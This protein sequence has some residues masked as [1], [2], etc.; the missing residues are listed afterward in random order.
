MTPSTI[1]VFGT[2]FSCGG[3]FEWNSQ[4]KKKN[5]L[6]ETNYGSLKDKDQYK[7]SYPYHL[8]QFINKN[9]NKKVNLYN[10]AKSGYGNERIYH[11]IYKLL[12]NNELD[13]SSLCLI[14]FSDYG[15]KQFYDKRENSHFIVNYSYDENKNGINIQ[16]SNIAYEHFYDDKN[17]VDKLLDIKQNI[18]E[19]YDKTFDVDYIFKEIEQNIFMLLSTLEYHKIPYV[20]TTE[21]PLHPNL[22]N[23][24]KYYKNSIVEY[25]RGEYST[26]IMSKYSVDNKLTIK[27]ETDGRYNDFHMGVG[28]NI[29]IAKQIYNFFVQRFTFNPLPSNYNFI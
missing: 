14:E 25:K 29:E 21:F 13:K 23:R 27:H 5:T 4:D 12:L 26:T 16:N 18:L 9:N 22:S 15:R 17:K 2:S 10:H 19:F 7:I 8:Q 1:H 24:L 6:L 11:E 28:G 3:G 20:I